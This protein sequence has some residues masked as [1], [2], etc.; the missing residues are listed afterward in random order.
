MTPEGKTKE[1]V[2]KVLKQYG[3]Y[4]HCPVMNGM[5]KPSLDFICCHKGRF[6]AIETK[7]PGKLPTPRQEGTM[8]EIALAEGL[9]FVID[10]DQCEGMLNLK[11]WLALRR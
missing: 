8:K 4:Y 5:G 6:F 3:A 9:C 2:K 10:S 11:A 1:L 7:A